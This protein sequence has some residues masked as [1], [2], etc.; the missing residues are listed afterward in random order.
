MAKH[1]DE[2]NNA[3]NFSYDYSNIPYSPNVRPHFHNGYEI[4]YYQKGDAVYMVEGKQYELSEGDILITNP[5]E[6][7][8]PVFKSDGEYTRSIIFLKPSYLSEFITDKYNP[9]SAL[10]KRKIGTQNKIDTKIAKKYELDKKINIIGS[11]ANSSLP[12]KEVMI[13]AYLLQF[14]VSLNKIVTT[15]VKTGSSSKIDKIIQYINNNIDQQ[16]SL[17][18]LESNFYL[19]K[20]HISHIFKEKTGFTILEYITHKRIM[21]AK[22]LILSGIPLVQIA[23]MVGFNDYSNFYKSFKKIIGTSPSRFQI[24]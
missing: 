6:L 8:C 9:F 19:S 16:I 17:E 13:K 12:E 22:E 7:H 24:I 23:E 4:L 18:I 20:Y 5:R 2:H 14:L 11:Y 15:E 1:Y 21:L 3:E 10:E